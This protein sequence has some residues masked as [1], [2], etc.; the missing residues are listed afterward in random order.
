MGGIWKPKGRK[1]YRL[2]FYRHDGKRQ[3][4]PGYR[5]KQASEAKLRKLEQEQERI[6]AGILSPDHAS[7]KKPLADLIIEYIADLRR[8]GKSEVHRYHQ[9]GFLVRLCK[10]EE[11]ET[12]SQVRHASMTV[13]LVHLDEKGYAA[14][15]SN[16]YRKCWK[17]FLDWCVDQGIIE[18]NPLLKVKPSKGGQNP[19]KRRAPTMQEWLSLLET[20]PERRRKIYFVAGLTGLRKGECKKL[21]R[22]DVDLD[23]QQLK[24]RAEATK[25][26]RAD[27]IPLLPDVIPCLK[28]LC[29]G[30]KPTDRVFKHFPATLTIANDILRAGIVSPDETIRFVN[31]HSLRYFYCVL[32]AK[33][34]PIQI[35]RL[36]MRHKD[37]TTTCRVYLDLGIQDAAEELL[38]LPSLI[39]HPLAHL[40]LR[41]DD[42]TGNRKKG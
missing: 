5:D 18:Q 3:T 11:W 35:V 39:A 23:S 1:A 9:K 22:R 33:R 40:G 37:L 30:L 42:V 16:H 17:C 6:A 32:L 41:P 10:W 14:K 7:A 4:A 12:L 29:E 21:E 8:Q 20:S 28:D 2:W 38:K 36:L 13:A 26:K 27:T 31:F 15:S 25:A 24:L 34:L 19:R